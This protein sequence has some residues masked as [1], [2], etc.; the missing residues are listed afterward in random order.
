MIST[1][2][3]QHW[4]SASSLSKPFRI[5]P[6]PFTEWKDL[7]FVVRYK[8]PIAA[9]FTAGLTSL[10]VLHLYSFTAT[11]QKGE[12]EQSRQLQSERTHRCG[13]RW[14]EQSHAHLT[15]LSHR[16]AGWQKTDP[17]HQEPLRG[18][19]TGNSK[20]RDRQVDSCRNKSIYF[21]KLWSLLWHTVWCCSK[22]FW[23]TSQTRAQR[24]TETAV[25]AF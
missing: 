8:F 10:A 21:K 15:W 1:H 23:S 14:T 12:Q 22:A 20:Q 25:A 11:Q 13:A 9:L 17:A 2:G 4:S 16:H 3:R 5:L 24:A 6:S 18:N 7:C 19:R